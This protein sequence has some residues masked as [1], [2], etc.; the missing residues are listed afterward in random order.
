MTSREYPA[1]PLVGIGIVVLRE[2]TVL[3]VRRTRPPSPGAW[4]LPGG[5]QR[6]GE[7]AEQAARRELLEETGLSVGPLH[8]AGH[9][10][11]IHTDPDGRIQFHY[12]ILDFCALYAGGQATPGGDA[13]AIHWAERDRLQHYDLWREG[14]QIIRESE[15]RLGGMSH[16]PQTPLRD[17]AV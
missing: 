4:S 12:T 9:V 6:L 11:S 7:T 10:D 8:L 17:S 1:R 15:A 5:A 13:G 3:L 14:I 2:N 16:P